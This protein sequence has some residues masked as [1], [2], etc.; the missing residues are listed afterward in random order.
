MRFTW[1]A[2]SLICSVGCVAAQEMIHVSDVDLP[3]A[4]CGDMAALRA[5][6]TGAPDPSPRSDAILRRLGV[7]CVGPLAAPRVRQRY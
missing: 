5:N 2:I 1:A 7:R 3:Y 6:L 4:A